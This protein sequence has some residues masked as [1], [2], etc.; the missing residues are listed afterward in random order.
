LQ[1]GSIAA[2]EGLFEAIREI[3]L[4]LDAFAGAVKEQDKGGAADEL[5]ARLS[6]LEAILSKVPFAGVKTGARC[7]VSR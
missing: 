7:R 4:A 3:G 6:D 1:H 2:E 5:A